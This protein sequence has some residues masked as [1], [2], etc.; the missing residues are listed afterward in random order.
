LCQTVCVVV[1]GRVAFEDSTILVDNTQPKPVKIPMSLH[2]SI[3]VSVRCDVSLGHSHR[4]GSARS[5]RVSLMAAVDDS[6]RPVIAKA[7]VQVIDLYKLSH[8]K[9]HVDLVT[10]ESTPY[11]RFK[12]KLHRRLSEASIRQIRIDNQH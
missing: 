9:H 10:V 8:A 11:L 12:T 5:V 2:R 7:E 4:V 6:I 3:P 1:T